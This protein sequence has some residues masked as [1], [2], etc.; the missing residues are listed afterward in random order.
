[1]KASKYEKLI[2]CPLIQSNNKS[3]GS[4]ML[5]MMDEATTTDIK[6]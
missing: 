2:T 5:K 1:M 6:K 3:R 4:E